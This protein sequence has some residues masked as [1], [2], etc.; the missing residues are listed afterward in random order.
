M[1]ITAVVIIFVIVITIFDFT[2]IVVVI[3]IVIV[4]TVNAFGVIIIAFIIIVLRV[5]RYV[6]AEPATPPA[7]ELDDF[8]EPGE[9]LLLYFGGVTLERPEWKDACYAI[10]GGLIKQRVT[11]LGF[12]IVTSY[13]IYFQDSAQEIM[14]VEV[15]LRSIATI[16]KINEAV[17]IKC[18]NFQVVN[19]SF[20]PAKPSRQKLYVLTYERLR[21]SV[22][23]HFWTM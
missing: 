2:V 4:I 7:L 6:E 9:V 19:L 15:P 10:D 5:I 21:I 13:R 12:V 22:F 23:L 1:I 16:E 8:L 11:F 3:G 17:V 14:P 20:T 18:K